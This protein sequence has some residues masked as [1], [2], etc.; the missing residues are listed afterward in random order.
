MAYP[1]HITVGEGGGGQILGSPEDLLKKTFFFMVKK[2]EE[3]NV[4]TI[5]KPLKLADG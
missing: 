3:R 1:M 2:V 5:F 4:F